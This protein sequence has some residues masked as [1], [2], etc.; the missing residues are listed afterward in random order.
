MI[1]H[2]I[3]FIALLFTIL[4]LS[5]KAESGFG[6][7]LTYD[8]RGLSVF[9]AGSYKT[10]YVETKININPYKSFPHNIS[11]QALPVHKPSNTEADN[12]F[13][14]ALAGSTKIASGILFLIAQKEMENRNIDLYLQRCDEAIKKSDPIFEKIEGKLSHV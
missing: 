6:L 9:L 5:L 7:E 10:D 2:K 4:P 11:L 12:A 14:I 13:A 8:H 3:T 1:A